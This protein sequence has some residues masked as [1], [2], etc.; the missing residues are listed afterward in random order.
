MKGSILAVLAG[1]ALIAYPRLVRGQEAEAPLTT[2]RPDFTESPLAVSPGRLQIELG[3][4][5]FDE[6]D[7]DRHAFGEVLGRVG[8]LSWLEGRIGLN[9]FAVSNTPGRAVEGLEDVSV[10]FKAA[11]VRPQARG[12]RAV[13]VTALVVGVTLPTGSDEVDAAD[14][15]QPGALV[16]L[17][18]SLGRG[19]SLGSNVGWR[20]GSTPE[21]RFHELRAS[22]S[23]G[24]GITERVSGF[25]EWYG[26][27]PE[28]VGG[29]ATNVVNGG[30]VL[31]LGPDAQLDAR[32]GLT[33]ESEPQRSWFT[34]LGFAFRL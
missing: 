30:L 14:G 12:P 6:G 4:S 26:I 15:V 20:Y 10:G 5:Y 31:L 24:L 1:A 8:V 2:D 9:S 27:Y 29:G 28:A 21:S 25:A 17:G 13:P 11:L 16:A 18:W 19:L 34:G 23:L 7:V 32:I 33:L 3:Y 22:A